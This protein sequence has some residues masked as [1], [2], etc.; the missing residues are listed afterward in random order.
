MV[1]ISAFWVKSN[2]VFTFSEVES[3]CDPF[4]S[5]GNSSAATNMQS[6]ST[7]RCQIPAP[8]DRL[9]CV[10]VVAALYGIAWLIAQAAPDLGQP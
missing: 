5:C 8:A 4:A 9:W 2:T 7:Y 6:S 1:E 10:G 3:Q